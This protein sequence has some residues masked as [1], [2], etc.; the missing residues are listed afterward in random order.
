MMVEIP[1][2]YMMDAKERLVRAENVPEGAKLEDQTV[3][4]IMEF[5][6]D[7]SAQIGRFK[8][9]C[10][11][12]VTEC[13]SL[14]AEKYGGT[15][16]GGKGNVTLTSFDGCKKVTVQIQDRITFGPELQIAKTRIDEVI[17]SWTEGANPN[18]KAIVDRAFQ[19]DKEGQIN[20]EAL[21]SLR[22]LEI[23]D[24]GW[25]QAMQALTDSIRVIGSREYIRFYRR[26]N[27]RARWRA[28]SI[29]IAAVD[30]PAEAA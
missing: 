18:L 24:E 25:K 1:E 17:S 23:D 27:P 30:A 7:L 26:P 8:G 22:R 19:V 13:V 16:G 3:N 15:K 11:D 4:T 9:H 14:L 10:F 2:G 28:V 12:D 20:R 5:A 21:F 6:D 29:D